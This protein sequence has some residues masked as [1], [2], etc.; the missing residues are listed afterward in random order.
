MDLLYADTTGGKLLLMVI[1][2][3][4]FVAVMALILF[5]VE[6]I[7]RAPRWVV[8]AAFTGPAL[9]GISFGLIYPAIL[10][11]RSSLYD[12]R[13]QNFIGVDNY[14]TAFTRPEFQQV[15]LNTIAWTI[16]VP[17]LSTAIG[18]I[19]AVLV[20]RARFEKIAKTLLFM[21][22]AISLWALRSSGSSSTNTGLSLRGSPQTGNPHK[23]G[24][25]TK[26]WCGWV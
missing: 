23:L 20:D 17:V 7:P 16:I 12:A 13:G 6:R 10:T 19:Y 4:M 22:M 9:L 8:V 5:A 3:A 24:Y 11:A 26:S 18:L 2:I 15:L 1:A 25:S 14:V 21:P